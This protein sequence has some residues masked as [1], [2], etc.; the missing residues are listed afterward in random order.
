[1]ATV[2]FEEVA[3][4]TRRGRRTNAE[5]FDP[6]ILGGIGPRLAEARI[7]KGES[8]AKAAAAVGVDKSMLYRYERGQ[9]V[10]GLL[11][12]AGLARHYGVTMEWIVYGQEA[13]E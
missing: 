5:T 8:M 6:V 13:K 1:M 4:V 7:V 12:A 11:I 2:R 3:G 9:A 10:P